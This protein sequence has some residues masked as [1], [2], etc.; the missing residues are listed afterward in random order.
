[1]LSG[2]IARPRTITVG[3]PAS[4]FTWS[5]DGKWIVFTQG[6]LYAMH[7]DSSG[8]HVIRREPGKPNAQ[9]A[10]HPPGPRIRLRLELAVA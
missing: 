1:M 10:S 3:G 4:E 9:V 5:A 6:G 2:R 8:R 7:P